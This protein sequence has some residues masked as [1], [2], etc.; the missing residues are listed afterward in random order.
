[1]KR[2]YPFH[3]CLPRTPYTAYILER[4]LGFYNAA[5]VKLRM[6]DIKIPPA[7]GKSSSVCNGFLYTTSPAIHIR[8]EDPPVKT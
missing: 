3:Q 8:H 2:N 4:C 7:K 5:F 6:Q 1:M